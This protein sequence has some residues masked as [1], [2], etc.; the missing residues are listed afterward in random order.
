MVSGCGAL[1][2]FDDVERA[3]YV[4]PVGEGG[5]GG[6]GANEAG[7]AGGFAGPGGRPG[8]EGGGG[9]GA[10]VGGA[11]GGA[12]GGFAGSNVGG[13]ASGNAGSGQAGG[14]SGEAGGGGEAGG[15][16][17]G[18][19]AT[20]GGGSGGSGGSGGGGPSCVP[21]N[22]EPNDEPKQAFGL[23]GNDACTTPEQRVDAIASGS[24]DDWFFAQGLLGLL[25]GRAA[26]RARLVA[27]GPARLCYY[28]Q[29]HS[30]LAIG[31]A[32]EAQVV[33]D[34]PGY[35][36]CCT[37][38]NKGVTFVYEGPL[39]DPPANLL[40]RVSARAPASCLPYTVFYDF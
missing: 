30:A 14:G 9:A 34:V 29:P 25:C 24:D 31:C 20:G 5:Q 36:G 38:E 3:S 19:G 39:S 18:G 32:G 27:Q 15:S 4:E 28:V 8:G 26:P 35:T 22:F 16:G 2:G 1:L 17:G 13:N 10:P 37:E 23:G 7:A 33:S 6:E 40:I 11:A 12:Q 21:D